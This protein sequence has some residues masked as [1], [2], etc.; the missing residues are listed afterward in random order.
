LSPVLAITLLLVAAANPARPQG[1]VLLIADAT[2]IDGVAATPRAHTSVL[3]EGERIVAVAPSDELDPPPGAERIEAS[4]RFLIP[5]LWDAHAHLS[6]W[7]ED[8]LRS[9]VEAG[10][11]SIR[12]LGGD[13]D[14]IGTWKAEIEAGERLGPAMIWCGPFLEGLDGADEYRLKIADEEEARYAARALQAIGVD[15]LKI[16]PLIDPV[17][18]RALVDE[19][20]DL[21]LYVVGH[22][23]RG[24]DAVQGAALGLRSIEHM[25]PY[26]ALDDGELDRVIAAYL[27]HGT[28]MSPALYSL[29]APLEARG[30]DPLQSERV[31]RAY[32]IVL[33]FHRAGVPILVGSNF[34]YRDWP[35]T[36]GL[37][38]HEE[39]RTMVQ[40]GIDE[41]TVI[42]LATAQAAR[43]AGRA[44]DSGTIE[45]GRIA[46]LVLLEADPLADIRHTRRIAMVMLR[47]RRQAR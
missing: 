23:P 41:M 10:V 33:R 47:G 16:Q 42:Q 29:V 15:F 45:V 20:A 7:G 19:A 32:E 25:D 2:V 4:G 3:I 31:Q 35:Q 8:A 11:T 18:V 14:A 27:E 28:W 9:L 21:G 1:R 40:A 43:F 46:D 13:P 36:P 17:L 24:L 12:E 44:Q 30:E 22:L 37:G 34:A 5:G 6:Y 38:L 26:T 39:M